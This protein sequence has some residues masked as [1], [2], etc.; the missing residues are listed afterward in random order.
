MSC[1]IVAGGSSGLG[2]E[3]ARQLMDKNYDVIIVGKTESKVVAAVNKLCDMHG[4]MCICTMGIGSSF[5]C[6]GNG[7]VGVAGMV[8]DLSEREES[9]RVFDFAKNGKKE[10]EILINCAGR[11]GRKAAKN[12]DGQYLFSVFKDNTMAMAMMSSVAL[13]NMQSGAIVNI[14]SSAALRGNANE[15]AYCMAKWGARGFHNALKEELKSLNMPL[16]LLAVYP[17]G[18]STP[19]WD[20]CKIPPDVS[21]FMSPQE[22]AEKIISAIPLKGNSCAVSELIIEKNL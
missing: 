20:N 22:V 5:Y 8:A 12:L 19:F 4:L 13:N 7:E 11:E 9:E 3:L 15:T 17:S 6:M 14:M 1:A 21:K 16:K 10:I 18:M 2:F